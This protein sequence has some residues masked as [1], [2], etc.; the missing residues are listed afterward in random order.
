MEQRTDSDLHASPMTLKS[1]MIM[2]AL[3]LTILGLLVAMDRTEWFQL[4]PA[5]GT[6]LAMSYAGAKPG[7]G[8][9]DGA[10]AAKSARPVRAQ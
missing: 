5:S 6:A 3:G 1:S 4:R 7:N 10:A 8:S 9:F 2:L